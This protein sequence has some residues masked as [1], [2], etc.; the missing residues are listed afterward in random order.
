[1][2]IETWALVLATLIGPV[3]AVIVGWWI[4]RLWSWP[5]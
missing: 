3:L 5:K 1:M 4:N 2:S